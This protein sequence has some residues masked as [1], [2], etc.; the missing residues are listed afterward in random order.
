MNNIWLI[1]VG[2]ISKDYVSVLNDLNVDYRV[3][4]RSEVNS[5]KFERETRV[6]VISGGIERHLDNNVSK[7]SHAIVAVGIE[8]LFDVTKLL[9]ENKVKNILV[10]KPGALSVQ[11]LVELNELAK[12]NSSNV[13]IG[14]NRRFFSSTLA[15]KS[16]ILE[17]GGVKSF[18]FEFTEWSHEIEK[19]KKP[20]KVFN[21]WFLANSSHVVDLAFYLGGAPKDFC[22]YYSGSL[23]WHK[24]ASIFAGAGV[25]EVGA[26]FSYQANWG[27]PG[28]WSVEILTNTLRLILRPMEKLQIQKIGSITMDYLDLNDKLDINFKPGFHKQ[29]NLFLENKLEDCCTLIEQIKNFEIYKKIANY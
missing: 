11:E 1:G 5:L 10:E 15:A 7:C 14:Y 26:L 18:N 28:R 4:G 24:S 6:N 20:T 12:T 3:I 16:I 23:D 8:N 19:L 2:D 21:N 13:I 29:V 27:A 25:S 17:E 9:I 22:S